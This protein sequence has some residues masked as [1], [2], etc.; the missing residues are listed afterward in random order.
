MALFLSALSFS[1]FLCSSHRGE[2][3]RFDF[4]LKNHMQLGKDWHLR[5]FEAGAKV[6]GGKFYYLKRGALLSIV[7]PP[8]C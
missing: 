8:S 1:F 5:H 3:P 2:K 6:S 4:H 7:S